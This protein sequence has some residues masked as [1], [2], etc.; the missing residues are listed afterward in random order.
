M[1]CFTDEVFPRKAKL[2]K[3]YIQYRENTRYTLQKSTRL[4][5]M[6][7]ACHPLVI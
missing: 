3:K 6:H 2:K 1:T 4:F 5:V 7:G